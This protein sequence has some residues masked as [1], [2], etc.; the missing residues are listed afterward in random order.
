MFMCAISGVVG[1]EVTEKTAQKMLSTMLRRGPDG[2]GIFRAPGC[3]LLHTSLAVIDPAGGSQPMTLAEPAETIVY[4][5]ELYNTI[6]LR[7][8]LQKLGH[9]FHTTS[10][11]E[12]VLHAYAQ[13]GAEC[14]QKMNGIFAFAVWE[15]EN[16]RLFFARDRM[17]V[18]PLFYRLFQGGL[19]IA[20]EMKTILAYPGSNAAI[21]CEG[22]AQI[23]LLGPGRLPGSGVFRDI[24]E[25]EPGEYGVFAAGTLKKYRYWKLTDRVFS[26]SFPETVERVRFLVTDSIRRQV[27]SDLLICTF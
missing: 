16:Q 19:L 2:S 21:D 1:L 8:E 25:L 14:L 6:E 5:G 4:N 11:T 27:V 20:S 7:Q 3:T 26:D 22:A 17:G 15:E 9:R 24:Q 12:V 18:K 10:D 23:L 13:W